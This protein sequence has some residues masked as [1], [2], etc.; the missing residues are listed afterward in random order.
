MIDTTAPTSGM[1]AAMNPPNTS[2]ITTSA[3]G[4]ATASP[5][6]RSLAE[7]FDDRVD[8]QRPAADQGRAIRGR[9]LAPGP[10]CARMAATA[11]STVAASGS[12]DPTPDTVA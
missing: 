4:S 6:C 9:P 5:R 3:I 2:S 8:E 10:P 11:R 7:T 1:P 12:P